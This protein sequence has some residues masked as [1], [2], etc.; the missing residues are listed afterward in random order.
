VKS[1]S[2]VILYTRDFLAVDSV[3][4]FLDSE[5]CLG[6]NRKDKNLPLSIGYG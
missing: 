1:F 5:D 6:K 2:E 3:D 4:Y